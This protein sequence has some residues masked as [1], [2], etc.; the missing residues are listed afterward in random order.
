MKRAAV[1]GLAAVVL[2]VGVGVGFVP[3][4]AQSSNGVSVNCGSGFVPARINEL[5]SAPRDV[6]IV[7]PITSAADDNVFEQCD[8]RQNVERLLAIALIAAAIAAL[9][10][11]RLVL[12]W[13]HRTAVGPHA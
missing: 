8:R 3:S 11:G 5:T 2:S 7:T 12:T 1:L 4:S 10:T 13:H 9:L 6:G